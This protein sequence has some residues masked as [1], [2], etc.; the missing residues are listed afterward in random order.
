ML[1]SFA[2]EVADL[3][4]ETFI[5]NS[6]DSLKWE[7]FDWL[8]WD[9]FKF[10]ITSVDYLL[11]QRGDECVIVTSWLQG[12]LGSN[13]GKRLRLNTLLSKLGICRRITSKNLRY[14]DQSELLR[15]NAPS[16]KV[17]KFC[18]KNCSTIAINNRNL[19]K[20]YRSMGFNDILFLD[21]W[22]RPEL[23]YFRSDQSDKVVNSI[24]HQPDRKDYSIYHHLVSY[25]G[26][27]KVHLCEGKQAEVAETMRKSDYYVFFN[28]PSPAISLFSGE[29]CGLSLLE[30]MACGCVCIAVEH[31]GNKF[32]LD[33]I[34]LI[35]DMD[36]INPLIESFNANPAR[37]EELRCKSTGIIEKNY[38][39]NETRRE[40]VHQLLKL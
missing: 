20:Y 9:K 40:S 8:C 2:Q 29:V 5:F 27:D 3:G 18:R 36:E 12:L 24:G 10:D 35:R 1:A 37:K 31:E 19:E 26:Q 15:S 38:R 33:E 23:F 7:D 34:T 6:Q 16:E 17:R 11:R 32:L 39:F 25:F 22:I 4:Y 13:F 28:Y 30:A 21:N 14:W